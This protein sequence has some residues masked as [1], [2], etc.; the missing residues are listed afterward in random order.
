MISIGFGGGGRCV[1]NWVDYILKLK[2]G[3]PEARG[4][5]VVVVDGPERDQYSLPGGQQIDTTDGSKEFFQLR[6]SPSGVIKAIARGQRVPFMSDWLSER[7]AQ[8][9]PNQSSMNPRSG[10]GGSRATGHATFYV[11]ADALEKM[12][13]TGLSEAIGYL[14]SSAAQTDGGA[15]GSQSLAILKFS[16]AGAMGAG[17]GLD[18]AHLIKHVKDENTMLI[19]VISLCNA[20]DAVIGDTAGRRKRD[21]KCIA[22]ERELL[23]FQHAND[24]I[25]RMGYT[26]SISVENDQL[27]GLCFLID[28]VATD[29][30]LNDVHPVY[31][32]CAAVADLE[33]ALVLDDRHIIPDIPNWVASIMGAAGIGRRFAT[34]GVHSYIFP[35][36]DLGE[37]FSLRYAR[38]LYDM[39]IGPPEEAEEGRQLADTLLDSY[40]FTRLGLRLFK[41]EY[42]SLAPPMDELA[43]SQLVG[44][45]DNFAWESVEADTFPSGEASGRILELSEEVQIGRSL[46]HS[47][48]NQEVMDE[49]QRVVHSYI[50]KPEDKPGNLTVYAWISKQ[51]EHITDEFEKR[52]ASD[53]EGIFYDPKTG[54]P[55]SLNVKPYVLVTGRDYLLWL[56]EVT[57]RMEQVFK[58]AY[59]RYADD[60]EVIAEQREVVDKLEQDM[61]LT[62]KNKQLQEEYVKESQRLMELQI[63]V[64]MVKAFADM[65]GRLRAITDGWW[66]EIGEPSQSW[67]SLLQRTR[68]HLDA[69]LSALLSNRTDMAGVKVRRYVPF[70]GDTAEEA[71]YRKLVGDHHNELLRRMSFS[72]HSLQKRSLGE[73]SQAGG[74]FGLYLNIPNVEGYDAKVDTERMYDVVRGG[75]TNLKVEDHSPYK[76][77]QY[78]KNFLEPL[79]AEMHLPEAMLYDYEH[80]WQPT[81]HEQEGGMEAYVVEVA[82]HLSEK[83]HVFLSQRPSSQGAA[84]SAVLKTYCL[85]RFMD[86]PNAESG[87]ADELATMF[88]MQMAERTGVHHIEEMDDMVICLNFQLGVSIYNWA[89]YNACL[90]Q[91][92]Q[93]LKDSEVDPIHLYPEE[94]NALKLEKLL[95]EERALGKDY[96]SPSAVKYLGDMESFSHLVMARALGLL[97]VKGGDMDKPDEYIVRVEAPGQ[98][99]GYSVVGLLPRAGQRYRQV[100]RSWEQR[101]ERRCQG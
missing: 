12:L 62:K 64:I 25:T 95:T 57:R 73:A 48:H 94:Q 33:T 63:W 67:Y 46:F 77:V 100:P 88:R 98:W 69:Q 9:I 36:A 23:R 14:P 5:R 34:F 82:S 81:K 92:T 101:R 83:A 15:G 91:Y 93:Y 75:Y 54:E 76:V 90:S 42:L 38:D 35:R 74:G 59:D 10:G 86:L 43:V 13:R 52:L 11:H 2:Y 45:I 96:L 24:F 30:S 16:T 66:R 7:E 60:E 61:L 58:E 70:P 3:S 89:Y 4:V 37:T 39:M 8:R 55:M 68:D 40:C 22:L 49:C 79:L 27:F 87:S 78:G 53:V 99:R 32:V 28:G 1:E 84:N 56:R 21:A 20:F 31:G 71:I 29:M 41:G 85:G 19:G 65:A 47:I 51:V 44:L 18:T 97:E 50:G 26:P 72:F 80:C 6:L 17:M